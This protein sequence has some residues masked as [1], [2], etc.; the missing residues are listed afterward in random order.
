[1]YSSI[2]HSLQEV[3]AGAKRLAQVI[4]GASHLAQTAVPRLLDR[5]DPAIQQWKLELRATLAE[6]ARFLTNG[7]ASIEGL[8][9]LEAGG[10]MYLMVHIDADV[11]DVQDDVEFS[12]VLLA[13]ENVFCLPGTCFGAKNVFRVVFCAPK[14]VLEEACRRIS[15]FCARHRID[16]KNY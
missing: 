5:D 6:Q 11:F 10:A 9:V 2:F 15:T 14:P 4:L 16:K 12:K 13:E 8:H 7:L 3:E 1:L